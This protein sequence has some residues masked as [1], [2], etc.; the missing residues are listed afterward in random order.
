MQNKIK[1]LLEKAIENHQ[2]NEIFI[3]EELYKE[4]INQDPNNYQAL[5]FLGIISCQRKKFRNS[6]VY[7]NKVIEKYSDNSHVI[8]GFR[9]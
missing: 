2:K 4:I 6:L 3:A 1:K 7:F 8:L 5:N 9:S